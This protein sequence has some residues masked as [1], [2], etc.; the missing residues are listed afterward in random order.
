M[1]NAYIVTGTLTDGTTVKL[2]EALPVSAGKVRVVL[3][4]PPAPLKPSLQQVM[5]GIWARQAARGH[6]PRPAEEIEAQIREERES[7][8]D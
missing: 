5:E 4:A 8:G 7:W 3:E 6:V 1:T 2:D